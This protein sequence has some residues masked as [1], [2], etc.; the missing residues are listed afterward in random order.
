MPK[1]FL[2]DDSMFVFPEK[3]DAS[4]EVVR[5]TNIGTPPVNDKL[6]DNITGHVGIKVGDKITTDHIMPAGARLKYRSNV[7]KYSEFVFESI[8]PTFSKRAM[9]DKQNGQATVIVA[10]ESYGQ[11]SSREHA[12]LCPMYLGVKAI[13]AKSVERIHAAN[14]VNF[15]IISLQFKNPTDYDKLEQG[16]EI[17]IPDIKKKLQKN[18]PVILVDKTKNLKIEL[19]YS[20]TQRQKEIL[21]EGGLLSYT[22]KSGGA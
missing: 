6:P 16:D 22:V 12:A 4:V 5:G 10:G 8:D 1:K 3:A 20:L 7:P 18:E 21:Y 13:V 11:G 15:G 19:R 9:A 14:L 2:I 17:Q